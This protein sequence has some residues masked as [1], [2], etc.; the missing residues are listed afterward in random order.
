ML[1]QKSLLKELRSTAGGVLAVLLTTL[2]TMVLIRALGRAA[3]GQVESEL[4]LPLIV[5][6][7]V[8]MMSTVLLLTVYIS[9]LMVLSRWWRDS[10]MVIWLASGKSL[11]DFVRPVV[12]FMWPL[13]VVIALLSIVVA[14][15]SRG[16]IVAFEDEVKNRGDA[17]RVS[18]GLFRESVSGQRVFFLE[19]PEDENGRIGTVFVRANESGGRQTVLMST[20]GWFENDAEGQQWVVLERGTRTDLGTNPLQSRIM[21]F[22]TYRIRLD[23][24][25]PITK[26]EEAA[27]IVP[28]WT[29]IERNEGSAKG[30]LAFRY[31]LPLLALGLG[32]LAIPLSVTNARSGRAANLIMA[33]LIYLISTNLFGAIKSG[34][35]QAKIS[36]AV[37][38]WVIP[39]LLLMLSALMLWWRSAQRRSPTDWLWAQFRRFVPSRESAAS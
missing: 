10:E 6:N 16:Q 12:Q 24:S 39:L 4:V 19:N 21:G 13:L 1:F 11:T 18:P 28:T 32:I 14:P 31:G 26:S 20:T 23:Q 29:L 34:V 7:T 25:T 37:S 2:I 17:Q 38:W 15:W 33:L 3:S 22:E 27:R 30:E 36:L 8:N 35:A 5:F 9:V